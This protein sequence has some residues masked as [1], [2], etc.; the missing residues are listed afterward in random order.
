M[1]KR[2]F[3]K[4]KK[5]TS[6]V[7]WDLF[8]TGFF[9]LFIFI[10][11]F[12][13]WNAVMMSFTDGIY[14]VE[15][16]YVSFWPEAFT[17]NNYKYIFSKDMFLP[18][19]K[20]TVL[21]T[22][23]GTVAGLLANSLL[24]YI[25]SRKRFIFKKSFSAFWTIALCAEA[26]MLPT[27]MLYYNL[28]LTRSFW[29]YIIP[30]IVNIMYAFIIRTYMKNLPEELE[31]SAKLDGAGDLTIFVKIISPLCL[32]VYGCVALFIATFHWNSWFDTFLY[33]RT[34]PEYATLQYELEKVLTSLFIFA[35][36]KTDRCTEVVSI[37]ARAAYTVLSLGP[38]II[39]YPFVQKY[40][41]TCIKVDG[42]K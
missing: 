2:K 30:N 19:L 35:N 37:S 36:T 12:P 38:I 42:I 21:R 8:L 14:L 22:I 6:D 3:S 34:A 31:D 13:V 5:K 33:N 17:L 4:K 20:I 28:N 27:M 11:I 25:L 15:H 41:S 40:F 23:I 9:L 18:E 1:K 16:N 26:G 39:I 32:P 10:T 24:A 7:I 29:V